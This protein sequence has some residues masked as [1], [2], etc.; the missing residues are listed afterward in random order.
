MSNPQAAV[1]YPIQLRTKDCGLI[2]YKKIHYQNQK[3]NLMILQRMLEGGGGFKSVNEQ[4]PKSRKQGSNQ[5]GRNLRDVRDYIYF[6]YI[7]N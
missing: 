5:V 6:H 4:L 2:G 3:K 1:Q 7:C